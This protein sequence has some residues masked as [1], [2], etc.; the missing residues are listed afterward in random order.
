MIKILTGPRAWAN[1]SLVRA[2]AAAARLSLC[3]VDDVTE[4]TILALALRAADHPAHYL[5]SIASLTIA[6]LGWLAGAAYSAATP[7]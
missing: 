3:M 2:A 1:Y 4:I 7:N 5:A 6:I